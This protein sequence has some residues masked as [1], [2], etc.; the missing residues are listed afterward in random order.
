MAEMA[1]DQWL[2][3]RDPLDVD[4][5]CL[6]SAEWKQQIELFFLPLLSI[7]SNLLL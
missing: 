2:P 3:N 6:Q 4:N 7:D 1:I 5:L